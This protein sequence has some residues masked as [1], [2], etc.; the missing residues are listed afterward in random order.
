M[1]V[2]GIRDVVTDGVDGLLVGSDEELA[3]ALV[4][5]LGD[6]ELA[7]RLGA[8]ARHSGER[9]VTTP[10]EFADRLAELLAPYTAAA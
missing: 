3:E 8:A 1:A 6:R 5:L 9:W 10:D 4:R 2:G 7:A